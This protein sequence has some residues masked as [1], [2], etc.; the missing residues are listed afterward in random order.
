LRLRKPRHV[1]LLIRAGQNRR[2]A[3]GSHLFAATESLPEAGRMTVGLQ[4]APGRAGRTAILALRFCPVTITRPKCRT[5]TAV[6]ALPATVGLTLVEAR[7]V[8]PPSDAAPAH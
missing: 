1:E 7:E 6:A 5:P 3:D 2:L 8:D 4:A